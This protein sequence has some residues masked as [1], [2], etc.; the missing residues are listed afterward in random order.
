M[1][2]MFWANG[3]RFTKALD[4]IRTIRKERTAELKV[5]AAKLEG[6]KKERDRADKVSEA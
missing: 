3:C 1:R 5:E 4:H 2:W 6:L